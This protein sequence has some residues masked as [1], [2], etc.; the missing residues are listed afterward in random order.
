MATLGGVLAGKTVRVFAEA[1]SA[2]MYDHVSEAELTK[3]GTTT[4]LT[5]GTD[6]YGD[7]AIFNG[8]LRA[9]YDIPASIVYV[10]TDSW[11]VAWYGSMGA[12]FG[13]HGMMIG[14][15]VNYDNYLWHT[16]ANLVQDNPASSY[17]LVPSPD[18]DAEVKAFFVVTHDTTG[19]T[20][21]RDGV[22]LGTKASQSK[23]IY[24]SIGDGAPSDDFALAGSLSQL[25]VIDG[26]L[27][28][29]EVT[30]W[31]A[32]PASVLATPSITL[33]G[34]D[35]VTEGT[36]AVTTGT[37]LDTVTT[38]SLATDDGAHSIEQTKGATTATSIA[39]TPE[40]GINDA[41]VGTP[42]NGIPLEA[43]ILSSGA[44]AYQLVQVVV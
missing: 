32:D 38:L 42:A 18:Y 17:T 35:T 27:T 31:S 6:A 1:S 11:T 37:L 3:G 41:V 4:E 13:N 9:W 12:G 22:D 26:T 7:L 10:N 36:S 5:Q 28:P 23:M 16:Q 44:T 2:G 39:F 33:T 14:S 34:P 29:A 30:T 15:G 24:N 20:L 25:S 8:A 21:Y 43:D 40:S 19:F